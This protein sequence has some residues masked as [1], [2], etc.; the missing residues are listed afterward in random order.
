MEI[1][2][3]AF[4]LGA[5]GWIERTHAPVVAS[6]ICG[7][8]NTSQYGWEWTCLSHAS[9]IDYKRGRGKE[10]QGEIGIMAC[11]RWTI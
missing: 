9:I 11:L 10:I 2:A 5:S 3:M 4:I 8:L 7:M 6:A 1:E